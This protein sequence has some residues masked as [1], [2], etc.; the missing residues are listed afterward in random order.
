M[1]LTLT[2]SKRDEKKKLF[3]GVFLR[4]FTL[5]VDLD[6]LTDERSRF[7]SSGGEAK[8]ETHLKGEL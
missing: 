8:C 1:R 2:K 6:R 3:F 5:A 7:V 4:F